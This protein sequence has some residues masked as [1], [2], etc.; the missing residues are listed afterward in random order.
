MSRKAFTLIELLVVIAIIAILA[1]I[2]FPV[3]AQAKEAAKAAACLSNMKNL[4]TATNIYLA[5]YDDTMPASVLSVGGVNQTAQFFSTP[6]NALGNG[7]AVPSAADINLRASFWGNA[8]QPYVK[9]WGVYRNTAPDWNL[10]TLDATA[11]AS[12]ITSS[13]AYNSYL[14]YYN[15]TGIQSPSRTILFF[16]GMG[17]GSIQGYTYYWPP[18]MVSS[19]T[20]TTA[21]PFIFARTAQI[22]PD[23]LYVF[24]G[25]RDSRIYKG[26]FNLVYTDS[27]AKFTKAASQRSP[28]SAINADGTPANGW[29][30][31]ITGQPAAC[32]DRYWYWH[33]PDQDKG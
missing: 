15:A 27:S 9:N 5:D 14:N 20:Q 1:A 16:Q 31:N 22:C 26:G 28:Y 18:F 7:G 19:G 10:F 12:R 30:S 21:V 8:I 33:A 24:A 2:L 25:Q 23:G 13:Y 6:A 4:G 32:Q 17:N 29:V 3:F 11:L